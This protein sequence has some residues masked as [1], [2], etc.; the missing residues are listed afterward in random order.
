MAATDMKDPKHFITDLKAFQQHIGGLLQQTVDTIKER[1]V[2]HESQPVLEG[3]WR[4]LSQLTG[5]V[6][7]MVE[8]WED[9]VPSY[10]VTEKLIEKE[11]SR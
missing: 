2:D 3:M 11:G 7:G 4:V 6:G 8:G 10:R 5:E 1:P 9:G